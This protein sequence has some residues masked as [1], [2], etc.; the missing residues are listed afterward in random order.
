[1]GKY[2][3]KAPTRESKHYKYGTTATGLDGRRW[4]VGHSSVG[5]KKRWYRHEYKPRTRRKDVQPFVWCSDFRPY[6]DNDWVSL[7]RLASGLRYKTLKIN[8]NESILLHKNWD[9]GWSSAS[10]R[11]SGVSDDTADFLKEIAAKNDNVNYADLIANFLN[12]QA[13]KRS[14]RIEDIRKLNARDITKLFRPPGSTGWFRAN[15]ISTVAVDSPL[16]KRFAAL[17]SDVDGNLDIAFNFILVYTKRRRGVI[18][19]SADYKDPTKYA[20]F[21]RVA[22]SNLLPDTYACEIDGPTK[23]FVLVNVL[24]AP[25]DAVMDTIRG[26]MRCANEITDC[27]CPGSG[28]DRR[29]VLAIAINDTMFYAELCNAQPPG[30]R[31]EKRIDMW[32]LIADELG[33]TLRGFS[34]KVVTSKGTL[35]ILRAGDVGDIWAIRHSIVDQFQNGGFTV[36]AGIL[37]NMKTQDQLAASID[38]GSLLVWAMVACL[39][40]HDYDPFLLVDGLDTEG[41]PSEQDAVSSLR[42]SLDRTLYDFVPSVGDA[43]N[44]DHWVKFAPTLRASGFVRLAETTRYPETYKPKFRSRQCYT[45]YLLTVPVARFIDRF[46]EELP[47][48]KGDAPMIRARAQRLENKLDLIFTLGLPSVRL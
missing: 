11:L 24:A 25:C 30:G 44:W 12:L 46:M 19:S 16:K 33:L 18:V 17:L 35:D 10:I 42:V 4:V 23:Q 40:Q 15:T 6:W 48:A 39:T 45:A 21:L 31:F 8:S 32:R 7:A 29:W 27:L 20:Q 14:G 22:R 41:N 37:R 36:S 3:R 5:S 47:R 13:S 38:R 28:G 34:Q 1:M 2:T 43:A 9:G 26:D